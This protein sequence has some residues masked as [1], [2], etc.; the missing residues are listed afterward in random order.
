MEPAHDLKELIKQVDGIIIQGYHFGGPHNKDY[1]IRVYWGYI[2]VI[3]RI[4]GYI[5]G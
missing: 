1:S 5:L 4:I 2:R 3:L